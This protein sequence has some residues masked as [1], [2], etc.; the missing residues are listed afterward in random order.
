MSDA[1]TEPATP[2]FAVSTRK[3]VVMSLCTLSFYEIYWFYKNWCLVRIRERS[4]I[5]PA[6]RAIFAYFFCY[7]LFAKIRAEGLERDLPIALP[8]GP[9]AI[10][11]IVATLLWKLPDPYWLVSLFAFLFLVPVQ[12]AANLINDK[13]APNHDRN[14]RFSAGNIA[15]MIIGGLLLVAG[16]I[17][18]FLP[19]QDG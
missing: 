19:A 15:T 1:P 18:A 11:W 12:R 14:D 4:N 17:G 6:M 10:G 13:V 5:F 7:S 8:A 3:L 2:Y 9:L 16:V